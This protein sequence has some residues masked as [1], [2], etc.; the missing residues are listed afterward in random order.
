MPLSCQE[1]AAF[2]GQTK[3]GDALAVLATR[4]AAPNDAVFRAYQNRPPLL[5]NIQAFSV[6]L[7]MDHIIQPKLARQVHA[8][9]F[10]LDEHHLAHAAQHDDL[11]PHE[12]A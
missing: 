12:A 7:N 9:T 5:G 4:R 11:K 2:F 3:G 6:N 8:V 1:Q 10:T